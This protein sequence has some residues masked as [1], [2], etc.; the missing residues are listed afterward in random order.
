MILKRD[1]SKAISIIKEFEGLK[2]GAYL[3]SAGIATIGYGTTRFKD[4]NVELGDRVTQAEADECLLTDNEKALMNLMEQR[5]NQISFLMQMQIE[6]EIR[7]LNAR[8]E[9]LEEQYMEKVK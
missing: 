6:A 3:C 9:W 2:L 5:L 7:R 1:L 8:I 4:R